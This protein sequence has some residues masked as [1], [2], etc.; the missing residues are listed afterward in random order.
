MVCV[1]RAI[2]HRTN[3]FKEWKLAYK[4]V[5]FATASF[6]MRCNT[7]HIACL[8][9]HIKL[10][11]QLQLLCVMCLVCL[12]SWMQIL[13]FLLHFLVTSFHN[14]FTFSVICIQIFTFSGYTVRL[15]NI[16]T[17]KKNLSLKLLIFLPFCLFLHHLV[18]ISYFEPSWPFIVGGC[19]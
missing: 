9:R 15:L 11:K 2:S 8:P 19:H 10:F 6:L 3:A 16:F 14:Y 7:S 4:S 18:V 12:I 17:G 13:F 5:H 1:H